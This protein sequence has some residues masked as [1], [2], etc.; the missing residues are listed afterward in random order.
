MLLG[1]QAPAHIQSQLPKSNYTCPKFALI[2]PIFAQ[3]QPI[4]LQK[5]FC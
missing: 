2:F 3:I 5:F 4:P 1:M